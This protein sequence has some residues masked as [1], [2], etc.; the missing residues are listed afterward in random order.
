MTVRRKTLSKA[1][2]TKIARLNRDIEVTAKYGLNG[3]YMCGRKAAYWNEHQARSVAGVRMAAGAPE[4]RAYECP[5]CGKWHL[6]HKEYSEV[7]YA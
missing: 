6:T 7:T 5:Y 1:Q 2:R 3:H 4:L